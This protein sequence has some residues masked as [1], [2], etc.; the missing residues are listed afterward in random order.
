MLASSDDVAAALGD[1]VCSRPV[2]VSQS[3][4]TISNTNAPVA[5]P[6]KRLDVKPKVMK[7]ITLKTTIK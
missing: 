1:A 3:A 6:A 5:A 4:S 7:K 2:D